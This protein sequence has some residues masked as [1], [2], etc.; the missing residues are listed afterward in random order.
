LTPK[1]PSAYGVVPDVEVVVMRTPWF[2]KLFPP[3]LKAPLTHADFH[4]MANAPSYRAPD[5]QELQRGPALAVP[6]ALPPEERRLLDAVI[7]QPEQDAP[8]LRMAEYYVKLRDPR[9]AFIRAQLADANISP[10]SSIVALAHETFAPWSG[11]DFVWRRGFV[12]GLSLAGRAFLCHGESILNLAPIQEVRLVAIQPYLKELAACQHL[13]KLKRLDLRDNRL[14]SAVLEVVRSPLAAQ[15]THWNL[16]GNLLTQA[17]RE[18]LA[19]I[20]RAV[21]L[22]DPEVVN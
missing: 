18:Y 6:V 11:R 1:L 17:D 12:T 19:R 5:A 22:D 13:L 21:E 3:C 8:R 10:H 20:G 15:I 16:Q 14:G 9:G 4:R 2:A 7:S